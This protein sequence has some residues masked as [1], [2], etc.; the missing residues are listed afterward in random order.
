MKRLALCLLLVLTA[1]ESVSATTYLYTGLSDFSLHINVYDYGEVNPFN[2]VYSQGNTLGDGGALVVSINTDL[3]T[4][5]IAGLFTVA[6][7]ITADMHPAVSLEEIL[8]GPKLFVAQKDLIPGVF[9]IDPLTGA[10]SLSQSPAEGF[11]E[12]LPP[13]G[14]QAEVVNFDPLVAWGNGLG[15]YGGFYTDLPGYGL[16]TEILFSGGLQFVGSYPTHET[17]EPGTMLLLG[18][19]LLG[20]ACF[21]RKYT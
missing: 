15:L 7:E 13:D 2:V 19:A 5:T 6:G 8:G 9:E 4:L 16:L 1:V 14:Q 21:R 3:N 12:F 11:I 17:P 10:F 20:G 18:S